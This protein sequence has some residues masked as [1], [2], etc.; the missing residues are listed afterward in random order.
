MIDDKPAIE[1]R[2]NPDAGRYEVTV[3][4]AAAGFAAYRYESEDRVVFF[5]TQVDDAFEG[6]GV[7]SALL[8]Y[9]LDDVRARGVRLVPQCP[10]VADYIQRH[11]DYAD[12][13]AV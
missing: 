8:R 2:D 13:V 5:H 10:F 9:A 1:V 11:Q 7:A 12:L 4:G 6:Q 3:D